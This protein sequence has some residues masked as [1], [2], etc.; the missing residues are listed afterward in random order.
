MGCMLV[1]IWSSLRWSD[2]LWISPITLAEDDELVR[3]I[4]TRTKTTKSWHALC[5]HQMRLAFRKYNIQLATKWLNLVRA[6]LQRTS[7]RFPNFQPDFL[8][9]HCGPS[10]DHPMFVAPLQRAQGVLVL[11]RFLLQSS[12]DASTTSVGVHSPKVTLL[13]WARQIGVSEEARMAQ[14][15][16][17]LSGARQTAALYGRDDVH[18]AIFLQRQVV[19]RI[20]LGFRPVIPMMRGGGKPVLDKPVSLPLSSVATTESDEVQVCLPDVN[21][22]VDTDSDFS[23]AD[24]LEDAPAA[25]PVP[26]LQAPMDDCIFL[27]NETSNVAHVA[28]CCL[29]DDP[30][31]VVTV[32]SSSVSRS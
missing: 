27:L 30:A 8:I 32:Q 22:L 25:L 2:A 29:P 4:A 11:R 14:G 12:S 13:S 20:S 26:I 6:A 18:P 10:T 1:L 7:E 24:E 31:C 5:I 15:H 16:H 17:R 19:H 3:G 9:P 23:S 21:D 28:A